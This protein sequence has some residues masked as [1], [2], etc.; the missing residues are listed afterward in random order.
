MVESSVETQLVP[1]L[2]HHHKSWTTFSIRH[3]FN[4]NLSE[5]QAIVISY[6][7]PTICVNY[8]KNEV[9]AFWVSLQ[10]VIIIFPFVCGDFLDAFLLKVYIYWRSYGATTPSFQSN[11]V[12]WT[13]SAGNWEIGFQLF[14]GLLE[15]RMAFHMLWEGLRVSISSRVPFKNLMACLKITAWH[16]NQR[17]LLSRLGLKCNIQILM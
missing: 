7:L 16:S 14:I 13:L 2:M 17:L 12:A 5:T 4:P 9:K 11:Q 6:L 8:C 10:L 15:L 3:P 1:F